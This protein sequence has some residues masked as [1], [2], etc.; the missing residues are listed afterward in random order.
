MSPCVSQVKTDLLGLLL[1]SQSSTLAGRGWPGKRS[2]NSDCG[3]P[4][5][6]ITIYYYCHQWQCSA[7]QYLPGFTWTPGQSWGAFDSVL[8]A[9]PSRA[10]ERSLP[11]G[12]RPVRRC[13]TNKAQPWIMRLKAYHMTWATQKQI[14]HHTCINTRVPHL[15]YNFTPLHLSV[16]G[17]SMLTERTQDQCH[18]A[19]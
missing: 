17:K 15:Q 18:E 8:W 5:H 11:G 13:E 12:H 16:L 4:Q 3:K 14:C 7:T 2:D 6:R 9:A 10:R 1:L 19:S